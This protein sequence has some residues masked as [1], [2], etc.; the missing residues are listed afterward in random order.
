MF[1]QNGHRLTSSFTSSKKFIKAKL[2]DIIG[3]RV[4]DEVK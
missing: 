4:V 3:N 1:G 2:L